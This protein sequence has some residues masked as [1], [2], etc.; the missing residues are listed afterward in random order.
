MKNFLKNFGVIISFTLA[1]ILDSQYGILEKLIK[2]PFWINVAKG[3]GALLLA[4]FTKE[5]LG[6]SSKK[7]KGAV[8]PNQG[9]KK[10]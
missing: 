2:E 6:L 7:P 1:F 8:I 9:F 4:Y 10:K 5:N 3:F